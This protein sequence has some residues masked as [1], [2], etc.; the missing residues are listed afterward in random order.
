MPRVFETVDI[1]ESLPLN[2][3]YF[4]KIE[5]LIPQIVFSRIE[6]WLFQNKCLL[7]LSMI[8]PA[9]MLW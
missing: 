1:S 6:N 7:N 4:I 2:Q 5:Q 3:F 8:H 9:S